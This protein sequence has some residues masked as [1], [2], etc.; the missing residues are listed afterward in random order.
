VST[1]GL[2]RAGRGASGAVV[3]QLAQALTSFV[4]HLAA[5]RQLGPSG[6]G[7]FALLYS[8]VVL[9]TAI[10]TGLVGD[11]LTVL[12]RAEP[13]IRSGLQLLGVGVALG[14]GI[15]AALLAW[16]TD[17]LDAIPA[18]VFGAVTASFLLEDLLRRLL[19]ASLR[20]WSVVVTDV[21]A[22]TVSLGW[23][24]V[25]YL[26]SS[27]LRLV[28]LLLALFVGQC[29]GMVVAARLLPQQERRWAP[30]RNA[31]LRSVLRFGS[32][33]AS[34]QAVRPA[35]LFVVRNVVIAAVG[36]ATFGQLEAARLYVSPALLLV[37]GVASFFFSSFAS[38]RREARSTLL[39]RADVGAVALFCMVVLFGVLAL[40]MLPWAE[41]V[42][43]AGAFELDGVAVV[44]W[45]A[46]AGCA[47]FVTAYGGLAAVSGAH[48]Q[49][50]L[51]RLVDAFVSAGVVAVTLFV[52]GL[53]ASWVPAALCPGA[54]LGG[55]II[56]QRVLVRDVVGSDQRSPGRQ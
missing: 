20:F 16:A 28:D 35:T 23:L 38:D 32:W 9:A 37:Q 26:T 44:G 49:V 52:L 17:L 43:T 54:V 18:L 33:R 46:Y 31:D 55:I 1:S 56:R 6:L 48:V 7:V 47:A 27:R 2:L 3:A 14:F 24:T 22:L 39:K 11:S 15:V 30:W 12:D 8:G 5:S 19:M 42:I 29:A 36:V 53:S 25:T 13:R 51:L 21:T 34:Q 4:L 40:A 45:L 10:S 41:D 50:F